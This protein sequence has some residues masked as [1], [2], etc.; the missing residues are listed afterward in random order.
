M[1]FKAFFHITYSK[2]DSKYLDNVSTRFS[3]TSN[4]WYNLCPQY[5]NNNDLDQNRQSLNNFKQ[6]Q[7]R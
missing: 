5:L 3:A 6:T 2:K 7:G 4:N 1:N